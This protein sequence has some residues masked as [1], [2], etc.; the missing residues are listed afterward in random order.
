MLLKFQQ[1]IKD[2]NNSLQKTSASTVENQVALIQYADVIKAYSRRS[3]LEP[4][5]EKLHSI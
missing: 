4:Q 1:E 3:S 2:W 5:G